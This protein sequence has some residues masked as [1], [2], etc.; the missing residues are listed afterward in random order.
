MRSS[1]VTVLAAMA[2]AGCDGGPATVAPPHR[3]NTMA[4]FRVTHVESNLEGLRTEGRG[5][6]AVTCGEM[7][8][9]LSFEEIGGVGA[10]IVRADYT[11]RDDHGYDQV[12]T[13]GAVLAMP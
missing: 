7:R 10:R 2:L 1:T 11:I 6:T 4:A 3:P 8:V 13:S 5:P 9:L 12:V